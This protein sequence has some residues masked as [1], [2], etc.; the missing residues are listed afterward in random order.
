MDLAMKAIGA[1]LCLTAVRLLL[2]ALEIRIVVIAAEPLARVNTFQGVLES[3]FG[4]FSE[5][6]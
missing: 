4:K 5:T 1:S 3:F 2:Q 6:P